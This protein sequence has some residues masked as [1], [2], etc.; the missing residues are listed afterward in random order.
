VGDTSQVGSYDPNGFGLYNMAGNVWEWVW[1]WYLDTF[2]NASPARN[3]TGPDSG[4]HRVLRGG[5]WVDNENYLRAADRLGDGSAST[6]VTSG[7]RCSRST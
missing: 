7:F 6:T 4:T 5:S 2:Y 1:D 3:P